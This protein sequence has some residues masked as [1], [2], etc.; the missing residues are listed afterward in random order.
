MDAGPQSTRTLAPLPGTGWLIDLHMHTTCSDGDHT[1]EEMVQGAIDLGLDLI[2]VT[3]HI[4]CPD[5]IQACLNENRLVCIPGQEVSP[6]WHIVGLGIT[7]PVSPDQPY[8]DIVAAIHNQGGLAM[9]AHPYTR[10]WRFDESTLIGI[11][12]DLMECWLSNPEE[13]QHQIDLGEQYGIACTYDSD[14]HEVLD[15]GLR[16]MDC[17]VEIRNLDELNSA[18]HNHQCQPSL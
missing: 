3:D 9:A 15:L 4:I 10:P 6:A 7:Q 12:L 8:A 5:V 11:G 14:A 18:L 16:Y 17:S 1:Y 2:A 13:N